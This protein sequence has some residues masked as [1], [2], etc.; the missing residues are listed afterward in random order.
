MKLGKLE[1]VPVEERL[2]LIA[3][4]V[5][6]S[7]KTNNLTDVL[8]AEIN[9]QLTDTAAFCKHY[10]INME[11]SAN[12]VIVEAKR[13]DKVW[14][15]AC[16]ILATARADINGIIRRHL[17]ARKA[18]FAPTNKAVLLTRMEFGGITPIGLPADWSLL[19]DTAVLETEKVVIGSGI[20]KS[21]LLVPGKLFG[22]LPNSITLSITKS[23]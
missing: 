12:C 4:S 8:V 1:F 17:E 13:A 10:N 16:L 20:K 22:S 5:N 18:S 7:T 15:A 19:V 11:V 21:K 3:S 14:Y 2:D 23:G 9:P 6:E